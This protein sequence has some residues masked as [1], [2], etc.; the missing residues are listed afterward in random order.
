M[1]AKDLNDMGKPR[2]TFK[3]SGFARFSDGTRVK[4]WF[5]LVQLIDTQLM[6]IT[7]IKRPIWDWVAASIEL[8]SFHGTLQDGRPV[9]VQ[10]FFIIENKQAP[11]GKTRLIGYSSNWIIGE[12][13]INEATSIFFELVNFRF[14]GTENEVFIEGSTQRST[15]SLMTLKLGEREIKLRWEPDY[16]RVVAALRAQ[17]GV[18]VTCTATA[19][20]ENSA[21][22][23]LA[24]A[25]METLCDIM[26]VARGTLVSWTSFDV[27]AGGSRPPLYSRYRDSVTRPFVGIELINSADREHTK[28]FLE[29]GF[30]RCQEIAPDFQVKKIARVFSDTRGGSFIESRSLLIGVLVEYLASVRSRLE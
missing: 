26:T 15:L 25:M 8:T 24:I 1:I 18:Q 22:I 29:R 28:S 6:F 9:S 19:T 14:L 27:K 7:D 10:G 12:P 13:N 21:D 2:R 20:I 16:D 30:L 23:D 3:G 11:Q 17:H 4:A 5:T